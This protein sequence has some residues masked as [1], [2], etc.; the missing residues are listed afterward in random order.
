MR[1]PPPFAPMLIPRCSQSAPSALRLRQPELRW[2]DRRED[3]GF[4]TP[5]SH[6]PHPTLSFASLSVT[7]TLQGVVDISEP[8]A[9]AALN[10][11]VQELTGDWR[12]FDLRSPSTAVSQPTGIA[13]TQR[14]GQAL[15]NCGVEGFRANSAKLSWH[16]TLVVFPDNMRKGSSIVYTQSGKV[17]HSISG[18]K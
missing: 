8:S 14:L 16:K 7:V 10:T 5:G 4:P 1:Q 2:G 17:V 3:G 18:T 11:S 6:M 15:F 13:P 12:G 9:Q